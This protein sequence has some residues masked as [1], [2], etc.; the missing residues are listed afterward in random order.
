MGDDGFDNKRIL[1]L[2]ATGTIGSAVA[3][4][5]GEAGADLCV[6]ARAGG[7]LDSLAG[8]LGAEAMPADLSQDSSIG[9]LADRVGALDG[10]VYAAGT[11]RIAPIKFLKRSVLD[12]SLQLNMIAPLLLTQQLLKRKKLN[13][14]AS[15]TWISSVS[16]SK[17]VAGYASYA[18]SKAALDASMRCLAVELAPKRIR[19]N[20][21]APGMIA[22]R[23]A[24]DAVDQMSAEAVDDHMADYP[25]GPGHA[26]D[27]ARAVRF[28]LS[29][30][31]R[32]VT[33]ALLP[34]DGGFSIV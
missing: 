33:G 29:D 6:S 19:V 21:L 32:W 2:G 8:E 17:G 20:C 13:P 7:R 30:A 9:S 23:M 15:V 27:V 34:V 5:L 11:A 28:L 26:E 4:V 24:E 3:R 12:E 1:V 10:F 16:A 25:L 31:S 22:G 18:A 14:G